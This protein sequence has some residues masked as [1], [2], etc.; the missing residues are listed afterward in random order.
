MTKLNYITILNILTKM[1]LI[2]LSER[3]SCTYHAKFVATLQ[4]PHPLQIY[5]QPFKDNYK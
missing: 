1:Y 5:T 2:I 3:C 4:N